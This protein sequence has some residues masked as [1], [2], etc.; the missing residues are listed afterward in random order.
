MSRARRHSAWYRT[1]ACRG[2]LAE[3]CLR[4]S[5][6]RA[7]SPAP[8]PVPG[9]GFPSGAG[10]ATL[11]LPARLACF[12]ARPS[13]VPAPRGAEL[14]ENPPSSELISL[15]GGVGWGV[16]GRREKKGSDREEGEGTPE[17]RAGESRAE[18]GAGDRKRDGKRWP[19]GESASPSPSALPSPSPRSRVRARPPPPPP[20][21]SM[22]GVAR[23]PL[24]LLSLPLLLLLLLLPRAGRPL[25]L[26]DYT[27][28]LGE[29]DAP[30]LLNYKDPCKAGER[31]PA[32]P[33]R[34]EA[35]RGQA[36]IEAPGRAGV[37]VGVVVGV[38]GGQSSVGSWELLGWQCSGGTKDRGRKGGGSL[39]DF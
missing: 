1:A 11:V 22:P 19:R 15:K 34:T 8:A 30:E 6:A 10:G 23:P 3:R 24:P 26:A 27:Y 28:D 38:G 12:P 32:P 17:P 33:G 5:L 21:A 9:S 13:T 35:G 29:E 37:G 31:P 4:A 25:D 39:G 16:G 2:P 36:G 18:R 20:P 7:P 14:G